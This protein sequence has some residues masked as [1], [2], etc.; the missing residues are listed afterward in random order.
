[1]IDLKEKYNCCGCTA[2][3]AICPKKCIVMEEDSEGFLYPVV[4]K[5]KCIDCHLCEKV[6]PIINVNAERKPLSI[7]ALKHKSENIRLKS[8]SGGAFSLLAE[9]VL[10]NNGVVFGAA[11]DKNWDVMHKYI[12]NIE[13]LDDLRRS[14][15]V[16]SKIGNTYSEALGFL[17]AGRIVLFTGSPCQISGLY[18]FLRKDYA[19]LLTMDF[20]C[21]SVPSP[22]V[23]RKYLEENY[24]RK[25]V[26]WKKYSFQSLKFTPTIRGVNFRDKT[27]GW[28]KYSFSLQLAEATAEGEKIQSYRS[29]FYDN[30]YMNFFLSDT[31]SRPSCFSCKSKSGRSGADVTIADYWWINEIHPEFDDDKG[32]SL[33]YI[34]STKG[35]K[36]LAN[37]RHLCELIQTD[38]V[39]DIEKAYLYEGAISVAAIPNKTRS[40]L[41]RRLDENSLEELRPLSKRVKS[42][43]EILSDALKCFAKAM[44]LFET[45]KYI[46]KKIK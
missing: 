9:Y 41:F 6:C 15:Y 33:V 34:Y 2:C 19:N 18:H 3:K 44:G 30:L 14:K 7:Y 40:E 32:C 35:E 28:K 43:R 11:F 24:T 21:H 23:W 38:S 25:G 8:S 37:T 45:G 42:C 12:E 17:K 16:Q 36:F 27:F 46:Y 26:G 4:D 1:M 20:V 22:K 31:I 10:H 29:Y 39:D 5:N 13:D